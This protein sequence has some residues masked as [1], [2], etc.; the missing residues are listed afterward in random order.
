MPIIG[1]RPEARY[2]EAIDRALHLLTALAE[3]GPGGSALT[4]LAT[5]TG[6]N[7][8]TA[9]GARSTMREHGFVSQSEPTGNYGSARRHGHWASGS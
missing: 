5:A 9:Y 2:V 6:V 1:S 7:K 4:N 3:A 8:S